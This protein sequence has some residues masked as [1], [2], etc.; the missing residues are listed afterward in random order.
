MALASLLPPVSVV[1]V[2]PLPG[3]WVLLCGPS[4][5]LSSWKAV[6]VLGQCFAPTERFVYPEER[7]QL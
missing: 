6:S 7:S 1:S 5:M 3:G 2:N 4:L